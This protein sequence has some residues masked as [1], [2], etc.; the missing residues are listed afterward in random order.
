MDAAIPATFDLQLRLQGANGWK[1]S[2][3]H[4][5]HNRS[6]Q[7]AAR[8]FDV[9]VPMGSDCAESLRR[10]YGVEPGKCTAPTLAPQD[11]EVS[12]AR[13]IP[14][15]LRRWT[16]PVC[17]SSASDFFR[18]GGENPSQALLRTSVRTNA[19]SRL[20]RSDA[21]LNGRELS[22][23]TW[24]VLPTSALEQLRDLYRTSH[25]FVFPTQQAL[26]P[27]GPGG[28]PRAFGLP[29]ISN[30]VGGVKDLVR[31]GEN[32]IVFSRDSTVDQWAIGVQPSHRG[33]GG[34]IAAMSLN[35][36]SFAESELSFDRFEKLIADVVERLRD[37]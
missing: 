19:A 25:I 34:E 6:F 4:Q 20:C 33:T 30:D 29:C 28:S 9:F 13:R 26:M 5:L 18:K 10:D 24:N 32:G 7:L 11:P 15:K 21:G 22:L 17:Y 35:A 16:P 12:K 31:D 23:Q 37:H 8:E 27:Q 3:A 1:R 36:R 2:L 14:P